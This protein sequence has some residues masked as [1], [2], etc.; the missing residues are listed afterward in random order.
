MST[1][2]V[3]PSTSGPAGRSGPSA[4]RRRAELAGPKV[5]ILPVVRI[6]RHETVPAAEAL[7]DTVDDLGLELRAGFSRTP[8]G[9][10]R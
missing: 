1:V 2:I 4:R 9:R 10:A 3:F 6:E 7:A 5:V 8:A